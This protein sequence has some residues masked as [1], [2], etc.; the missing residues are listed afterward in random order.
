MWVCLL[1]IELVIFSVICNHNTLATSLFL[2]L[3]KINLDLL[4]HLLNLRFFQDLGLRPVI[5]LPRFAV[6]RLVY[7]RYF[8]LVKMLQLSLLIHPLRS[9]LLRCDLCQIAQTVFLRIQCGKSTLLNFRLSDNSKLSRQVR[10]FL[11][12]QCKSQICNVQMFSLTAFGLFLKFL[13]RPYIWF[14]RRCALLLCM[15]S[16]INCLRQKGTFSLSKTRLWLWWVWGWFW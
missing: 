1:P 11:K 8:V 13:E 6:N 5:N 12:V 7:F 14:K 3:L 4:L 9:G 15:V 16:I 2:L 10:I